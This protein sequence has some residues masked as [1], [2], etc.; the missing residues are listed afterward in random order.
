MHHNKHTEKD[1]KES[2]VNPLTRWE[3]AG[4]RG[5]MGGRVGTL[6]LSERATPPQTIPRTG[7]CSQSCVCEECCTVV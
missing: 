7:G 6:H 4:R 5:S 1:E 3:G 2:R